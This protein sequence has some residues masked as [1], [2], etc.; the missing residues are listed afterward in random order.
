[1]LSVIV[2]TKIVSPHVLYCSF[3]VVP[4]LIDHIELAKLDSCICSVAFKFCYVV[5][6]NVVVERSRV[7]ARTLIMVFS[8]V[9]LAR[10]KAEI[11]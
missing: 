11:F 3:S 2:I 4:G 10:E 8:N 7:R 5:R 1:M 6:K 9:Q